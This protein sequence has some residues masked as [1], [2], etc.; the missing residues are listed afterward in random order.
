[1]QDHRRYHGHIGGEAESLAFPDRASGE[2]GA[3]SPR[4]PDAFCRQLL[5]AVEQSPVAIAITDL[6]G[7]I[8]FANQCYLEITGYPREEL[9]G[10]TPAMIQS[11]ETPE[12]VYRDLWGAILAGRVWQGE[13]LN[14]RRNGELYW[15]SEVITPVRNDQGKLVSF[16]AVKE[17]I[18][19]RRRQEQELRL[20]ATVFETGQATLITDAEMRIEKV[21]QAFTDIT[22]YE[23]DEVRG[24]TPRLFKSGRHDKAFYRR[25]WQTLLE[26][27]HWQGE[28]WNRNKYG[29]IY[30]LWQSI[31]A[32][33]DEMGEVRN[34]VAVF[35]NISERK[36]MEQ[37]LEHQATRDHLTGAYNRRAFDAALRQ[38]VSKANQD[39]EPFALLLFDIDHFKSVNDRHGHEMG[40]EILRRL[41]QRI[42]ESLRNTDLLARWG[43]E[44][45]T[46]LLPDTRLQGA[47]TFAERL[48]RQIADS[49]I[50][51][52]SVTVSI[53]ITAYRPG[54]DADRLLSRADDA[55]YRAKKAG[56]NS[57]VIHTEPVEGVQE[58]P[59]A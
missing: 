34:Y 52:L 36:R 30:P 9:L 43:G 32:V 47:A 3:T 22:G 55:L 46:I 49:R 10:R 25:L 56:R 7:R 18:T 11:G 33:Q 48:R 42:R 38:S 17:D 1:M 14:R 26:T 39:G 24:E 31:T 5:I 20:L 8:E 28:I 15:A 29:E 37:E 23:E 19:E 4:A 45:F 27:G 16:V 54:D 41:A 57:V 12:S 35:H 21:N 58:G 44:E 40:D 2:E 51:G 50:R 59:A 13:L 53:G 6:A